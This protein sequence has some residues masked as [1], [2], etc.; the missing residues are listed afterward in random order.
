[1]SQTDNSRIYIRYTGTAVATGTIPV[2][3]LISS[4]QGF[5]TAFRKVARRR[6]LPVDALQLEEIQSGSFILVLGPIS[7]EHISATG[8]AVSA[9]MAAVNAITA[10]IVAM[11]NRKS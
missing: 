7:P 9:A 8:A 6:A 3:D 10:V 11:R 1:M 4:L 5:A 2:D